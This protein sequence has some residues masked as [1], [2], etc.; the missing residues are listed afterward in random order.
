MYLDYSKND[1]H[2]KYTRSVVRARASLN[3]IKFHERA[4]NCALGRT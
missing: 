1:E 3:K 2:E 4:E